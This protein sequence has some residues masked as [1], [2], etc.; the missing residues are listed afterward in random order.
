MPFW[1]AMVLRVSLFIDFQNAYR[2]ARTAF[3]DDER[4]PSSYGQIA[5]RSLGELLAASRP[6][7]SSSGDRVLQDVRVYRGMPRL[8]D[9]AYLPAQRQHEL[10]EQSGVVVVTRPVAG[11]LGKT[12]EKGIDV[13]LALDF[14][15][16]ALDG[17]FD[18]GII[19]S[20]DAD[21]LPAFEKV[22]DPGRGLSVAV[23]LAT[24]WNPP[25]MAPRIARSL[26]IPHHRLGASDYE[27]VRDRRN[28]TIA[29]E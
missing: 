5:P 19:F 6:P 13:E 4:D 3:H 9:R 18:M 20:A 10:W 24:W 15:A 22:L 25:A 12:R 2:G 26:R 11:P 1:G 14:F 29:E 23:E 16:G 17:D 27:R 8:D 28:Y 7:G 21:I